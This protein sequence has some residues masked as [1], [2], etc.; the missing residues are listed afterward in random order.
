MFWLKFFSDYVHT[1]HG[2]MKF[3]LTPKEHIELNGKIP[4]IKDE[5]I[6]ILSSGKKIR[7]KQLG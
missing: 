7:V 5:D 3:K 6:I 2:T 1:L 4:N